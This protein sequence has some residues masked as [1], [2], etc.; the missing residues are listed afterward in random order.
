[1]R[2]AGSGSARRAWAAL[3]S[4]QAAAASLPSMAGYIA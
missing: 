2:T 4:T 3:R 1:V